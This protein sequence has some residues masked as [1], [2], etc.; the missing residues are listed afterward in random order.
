MMLNRYVIASVVEAIPC[1]LRDCF[2]L[3]VMT[4]NKEKYLNVS[5]RLRGSKGLIL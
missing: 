3:F 4:Q 2:T 1:L 5:S